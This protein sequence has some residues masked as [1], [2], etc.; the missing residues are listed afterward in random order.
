MRNS[1]SDDDEFD[2]V[3]V[4][5]GAAG[6][7]I[8]GELSKD[9]NVSVCL[10]EAGPPDHNLYIHVPAGFVKMIADP[11]YTWQFATEPTNNTGGRAIALTQG[12]TLGGSTA[13]NGMIVNRGQARDFDGWAAAGNAGWSYADVLP[14]FRKLE[15][16]P[17]GDQ[18]VR[19][20]GGAL[21]VSDLRWRSPVLD[22]FVAGAVSEG[23]A[24]NADYNGASQPGIGYSQSAIRNR[25]RVSAARAFLSPARRRPN[26]SVLTNAP[27][28]RILFEGK[29]ATGVKYG[30]DGATRAVRAR[31]EVIVSAGTINTARLL[32]VSG[33]G[34]PAWLSALGVPVVHALTGVGRNFR[35]HYLVNVSA[36]GRNYRSI[37]QQAA[38][39]AL[40][41][42][43]ARWVVGLPSIL[44]LSP[45][46]LQWFVDSGED[47]GHADIQGVFSPA[48]KRFGRAELLDRTNGMTCGFWQH[49]PESSGHVR[50]R[51]T[52]IADAPIVQPN[53]LS[54]DTDRRVVIAA[55]KWARRLLNSKPMAHFFVT[56]T[57]PGMAIQSD[58][59]W[60][61]Y[62]RENGTTAYHP[63]GT[64]SMGP[65][66]NPGSVVDA[67]LSVHG[68]Q[69]LR[70]A[71]ASIMPRMLSANTQTTTIM[72]GLKAADMIRE[73]A[74]KRLAA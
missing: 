57:R 16:R 43:V 11:D 39:P 28:S 9:P 52:D 20:S 25:R 12:R 24:V 40:W 46:L 74:S 72:I 58:A 4:G 55:C 34:D 69:G 38:A 5:A 14:Y 35:D 56:E 36:E 21:T 49:R 33:V 29:R 65:A 17:Q 61:D 42:Q 45:P 70:V 53:Y 62:A 37:N 3:I 48:S 71:D 1:V 7:A 27:V 44:E 26:L 22:A 60:L 64:A 47:P 18:S 31:R 15:H 50:A 30:R 63:V 73:D 41:W 54:E 68:V 13:I 66:G 10:L 19:G 6:C 2:Y 67:R 59:Q 51:S 32:Q 23:V 8:A